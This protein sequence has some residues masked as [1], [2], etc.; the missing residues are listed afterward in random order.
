MTKFKKDSVIAFA[1]SFGVFLLATA[2]TGGW[3]FHLVPIGHLD[4][5]W[6][7]PWA[8]SVLAIGLTVGGLLGYTI[9]KLITMKE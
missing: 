5:W 7:M 4:V 8:Y 1:I 2:W 9:N 3:L 6:E